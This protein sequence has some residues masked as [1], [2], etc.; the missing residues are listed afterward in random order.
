MWRRE[1]LGKQR[2]AAVDLLFRRRRPISTAGRK[3]TLMLIFAQ[4]QSTP[5]HVFWGSKA[6]ISGS[7][8]PEHGSRHSCSRRRRAAE[9]NAVTRR[10]TNSLRPYRVVAKKPRRWPTNICLVATSARTAAG[11]GLHILPRPPPPFRS[12]RVL[13]KAETR[14]RYASPR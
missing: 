4:Q 5:S 13:L 8:R 3:N 7:R 12:M 14:L 2:L 11:L 9:P 6:V 1:L 10:T